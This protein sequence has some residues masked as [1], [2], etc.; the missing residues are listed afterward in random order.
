MTASVVI[1]NLAY[2]VGAVVLAI[3]GGLIVVWFHRR[4]TSTEAHLETFNR[5]L[6]ALSP[7]GATKSQS[8]GIRRLPAPVVGHEV[9]DRVRV[10][11]AGR[12]AAQVPG[13]A[14]QEAEAG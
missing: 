13:P 2:L 6:Q 8:V 4:P 10:P 1:S 12:Q 9:I 14:G 5:G 7:E 11:E 3:I